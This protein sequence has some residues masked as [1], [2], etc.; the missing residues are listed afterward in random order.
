MLKEGDKAPAFKL[1]DEN[2]TPTALEQFSG[3][4]VVVYFYPKD[5]TPGCTTE[6]CSFRDNY[7]AILER[8]AVVIGIS[9][10]NE[11]SH[12][13][14]KK[15]YDLPF[16]LLS[17]PEK[18]VIMAFGA[19]GEKK[20]YGKTYEGII[21]STFLIDEDGTIRKVWPK[22]TPKN[23]AEDVLFRQ[24]TSSETRLRPR[25]NRHELRGGSA[26]NRLTVL[27]GHPEDPAEF[28]RYYREVH[29][30]IATKMQG[31]KGWTIGKC[32]AANTGERPPYYMIVGL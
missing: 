3:K 28:D 22:V 12:Q 18:T 31:L 27:Y 21:R 8:G 13:K 16:Y 32:E 19:W 11:S 2:G 25:S 4:K 14:F 7:S 26:M 1:N 17:D 9:A 30:P 23:H 29:I 24:E 5:D 15:K 6:S 10:D 20:M